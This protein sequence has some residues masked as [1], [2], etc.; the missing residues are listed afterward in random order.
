M[1]IRD[2]TKG[3]E[4]LE[5]W[6]IQRLNPRI[7]FR[8]YDFLRESVKISLIE[9][10]SAVAQPVRFLHEAYVRIG[11]ITRNLKEFPDKERKIWQSSPKKKFETKIA[12]S[13]VSSSEINGILSFETYFELLTIPIPTRIEHMISRFEEEKLITRSGTCLLYT[14]PSPRDATL[15]RMPSSA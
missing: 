2:R 12:L 1:C 4:E 14:S 3:N 13:G 7:D 10:P 11:S 15:S 5:H 8:V 6:I 9:I